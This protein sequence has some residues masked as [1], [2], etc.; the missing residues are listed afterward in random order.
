MHRV[1]GATP[2]AAPLRPARVAPS[3]NGCS[4][5]SSSSPAGISHSSAAD[6]VSVLMNQRDP[7][8]VIER[9]DP[10]GARMHHEISRH[11]GL[12]VKPTRSVTTSH[13][14]PRERRSVRSM[15]FA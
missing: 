14:A 2:S 6:R 3:A 9:D 13:F 5:G 12:A 1:P 8:I 10:D 7:L 15:H 11:H 4:P